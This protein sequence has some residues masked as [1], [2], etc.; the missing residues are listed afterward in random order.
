MKKEEILKLSQKENEGKLDERE[1][2]I[3]GKSS[4]IG[5]GVGIVICLILVILSRYFFNAPEV[6]LSAFLVLVAMNASDALTNYFYT[7]T[8]S[9]LV[10]G[11]IDIILAIIFAVAL[12]IKL[13]G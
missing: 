11:I 9:K 5:M 7:K 13:V 3:A 8:R 10:I 4:T 6:A 2:S 1:L 12:M